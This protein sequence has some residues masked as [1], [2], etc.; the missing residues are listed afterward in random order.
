MK[1]IDYVK[2]MSENDL[3]NFI[4]TIANECS[5]CRKPDNLPCQLKKEI[6]WCN[7]DEIRNWL[8]AEKNLNEK[9]VSYEVF[10]IVDTREIFVG[11]SDLPLVAECIANNNLGSAK[12]PKT[13][14]YEITRENDHILEQKIIQEF[15][16]ES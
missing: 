8:S 3:A 16:A 11:S 15:S 5:S 10:G 14:I 1:Q 6:H 2:E 9:I 4:S 12:Y 7:P 13:I